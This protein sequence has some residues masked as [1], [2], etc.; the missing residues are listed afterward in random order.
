MRREQSKAIEIQRLNE[1]ISACWGANVRTRADDLEHETDFSYTHVIKPWVLDKVVRCSTPES[2]ILDVGC[3]CGFLSNVIYESGRTHIRGID[4]S[5]ASVE[6]ARKRYPDISFACGDICSYIPEEKYDLCL[7]IMTLNNLPDIEGF[8]LA[9]R[10]LILNSGRVIIVIPHPCY[11]PQRHLTNQ[12]Y[13]YFREKPYEYVFSTKGRAD[14]AANILYF[15]RTL[16]TYYRCIEDGGFRVVQ[17]QELWEGSDK[18]AP[19]ILG[20]EL[21]LV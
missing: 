14:Y 19:D 13:S 16:E 7:S 10:R 12:D 20:L 3:G 4:I 6:Y 9:T 15:H 18:S 5:P 21:A 1:R 2:L 17:R 11:W 8:F